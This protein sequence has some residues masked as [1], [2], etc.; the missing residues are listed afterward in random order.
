MKIISW[1]VASLPALKGFI[2]HEKGSMK[3][4]LDDLGVDIMCFQGGKS[5]IGKKGVG[6]REARGKGKRG[7][8]RG[9]A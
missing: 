6:K 5:R 7:D 9:H 8:G 1:N 3:Q 4:F 2:E